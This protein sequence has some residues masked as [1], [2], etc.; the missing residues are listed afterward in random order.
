MTG[1]PIQRCVTI[2]FA[3]VV[4]LTASLIGLAGAVPQVVRARRTSVEGL[5]WGSQLLTLAT[6]TLWAVYG[7]SVL[8][9]IQV[10]NN[11]AALGLN[12]LLVAAIVAAQPTSRP[13]Q[14][15]GVITTTAIIAVLIAWL[16]NPLV[17]GMIGSVIGSVRLVPQLRLALTRQPLWGLDPWAV[18]LA[19]GSSGI[20]L[21]YGLAAT[22]IAVISSAGLAVLINTTICAYRL[23]PRRTLRSIADG[24]IGPH[25]ARCAAPVATLVRAPINTGPA[26]HA[27]MSIAS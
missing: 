13:A 12:G 19:L 8:D 14:A 20:W 16:I 1:V 27:S 17:V 25:A 3:L 24:R 4:G 21:A 7:F 26:L 23:P 15:V 5:S 18:Q 22:D 6:C 2:T 10:F 9:G 11:I